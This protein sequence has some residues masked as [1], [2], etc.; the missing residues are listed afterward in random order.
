MEYKIKYLEM[1][2]NIISRMASNSFLLKGWMI[3]LLVAIFTFTKNKIE[4]NCLLLMSI[5]I[6]SIFYFLDSYYLQLECKY[7]NLYNKVRKIEYEDIDFSM[8]ITDDLLSKKTKYH[9]CLLSKSEIVF[10]GCF[11]IL[12]LFIYLY[13]K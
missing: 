1:I 6:I 4:N 13:N 3:S 2:Q 11:Y 9:K 10:Y 5:F 7:R 12:I 8:D